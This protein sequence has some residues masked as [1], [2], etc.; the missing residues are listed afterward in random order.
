MINIGIKDYKS[1]IS[2]THSFE[3]NILKGFANGFKGV[4]GA[5]KF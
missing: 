2:K 5:K 3:S 4:K 1:R